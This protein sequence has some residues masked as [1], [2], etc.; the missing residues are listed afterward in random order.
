M[1]TWIV[2]IVQAMALC[3]TLP[4]LAVSDAP[5]PAQIVPAAVTLPVEGYL[6]DDDAAIGHLQTNIAAISIVG[7]DGVSLTSSGARLTA[8]PDI[9]AEA[10][11]LAHRNH[12]LAE[13]LLSNY[14]DSVGDFS[15]KIAARLL[16]S[17][18]HRAAVAKALAA[19]VKKAGFDG[20]QID[21]E[22]MKKADGPGLTAF[23]KKLRKALPARKT[24]SM[25]VMSSS[26]VSGYKAGGYQLTTLRRYVNRFVLMAYD[27]HGPGWSSAGPV[28][29]TPWVR[30]VLAAFVRA[31]VPLSRIDLGVAQYGYVWP[32]DG[33]QG[34]SLGVNQAR[35]LAGDLARF[36]ATQQEWTATLADGSVLWWSDR[37]TLAARR[38]L[39][40][41]AGVHGLAVWEL[42]LADPLS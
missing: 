32:G 8:T 19:R 20:V 35:A 42:S 34:R 16:R 36:D 21:L 18:R 10:I 9:S 40:A 29:G 14:S 41:D 28:G 17:P 25:A 7:I 39:A 37:D 26:S 11:A 12:K 1:F 23:V 6:M 33:S 38:E 27:Q 2:I 3:V 31:K 24:I 15:P 4:A 13:L 30:T 22:S 5:S